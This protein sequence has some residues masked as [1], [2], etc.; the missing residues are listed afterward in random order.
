MRIGSTRAWV[1][2]DILLLISSAFSNQLKNH[3]DPEDLVSTPRSL[4]NKTKI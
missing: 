4:I 1:Q 3:L 2:V